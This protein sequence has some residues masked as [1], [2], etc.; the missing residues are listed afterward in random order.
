MVV[1]AQ[2]AGQ[3]KFVYCEV[4]RVRNMQYYFKNNS[5]ATY[6]AAKGQGKIIKI[7]PAILGRS[8]SAVTVLAPA[9]SAG[10]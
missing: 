9:G 5:S 2:R 10:L 3:H 8:N 7:V 1:E 6:V 4:L